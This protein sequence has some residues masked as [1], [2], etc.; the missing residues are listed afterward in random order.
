LAKFFHTHFFAPLGM[1]HTALD[2]ETEIA[3]GRAHGYSGTA[4]HKFTNPPF[5]SMSIPGAAGAIRSNAGDLVKWNA[6]L[7][8]GKILKPASLAEMLAPGKLNSGETSGAKMRKE[9]AAAGAP[10]SGNAEYGYALFL[11]DVDGHRKIDHG[12]GI[13]GFSSSL[14]QFPD[15]HVTVAVLANSIGKD[16]GVQKIAKQIERLAI[17]LPPAK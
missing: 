17:A 14:S 6:A 11:S 9:M 2:D 15:D 13:F 5:I 3:H 1:T 12:G 4:P 16:V 8:G 10:P 7:Y